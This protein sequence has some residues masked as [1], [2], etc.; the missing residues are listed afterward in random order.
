M[1]ELAHSNDATHTI[2]GTHIIGNHTSA[3]VVALPQ[4]IEPDFTIES[5][6]NVHTATVV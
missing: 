5:T 3:I 1:A 6:R 2:K 4:G